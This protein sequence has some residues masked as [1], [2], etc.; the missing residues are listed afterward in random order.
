MNQIINELFNQFSDIRYVAIYYKSELT[1]Q[2][3]NE[4][5]VGAS[6]GD[7]DKYE[8]L[9]VN[10]G[11]LKLATQRAEIDFEI[12]FELL[13]EPDEYYPNNFGNIFWNIY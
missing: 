9:I 13:S 6:S 10:P 7:S 1:K 11:L 8:E 5:L 4:E 3:R 12:R 2:Q